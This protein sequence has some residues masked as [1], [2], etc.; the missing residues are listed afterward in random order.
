[1]NSRL[2]GKTMRSLESFTPQNMAPLGRSHVVEILLFDRVFVFEHHGL[3]MG[4]EQLSQPSNSFH[5]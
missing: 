1:M 2:L 3:G 5:R 4:A